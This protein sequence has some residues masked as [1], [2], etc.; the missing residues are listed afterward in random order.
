MGE[1]CRLYNSSNLSNRV[2]FCLIELD[3]LVL[4]IALDVYGNH[5]INRGNSYPELGSF[6]QVEVEYVIQLGAI[7][8]AGQI[9]D[10]VISCVTVLGS[11]GN[12]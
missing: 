9:K 10:F 11:K 5:S 12:T 1:I 2:S 4:A 7:D 3:T 6:S 8:I